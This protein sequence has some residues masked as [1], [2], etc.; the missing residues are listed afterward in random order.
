MKVLYILTFLFLLSFTVSGQILPPSPDAPEITVIGKKWR[1]EK[2]NNALDED[3]FRDLNN[4]KQAI[5]DR[6]ITDNNNKI[7][8]ASGEPPRATPVRMNSIE[9]PRVLSSDVKYIYEIKIK[10][11]GEKAI[12][13]ISCQYI[14]SEPDTQKQIS[15]VSFDKEININPGKTE[16]LTLISLSPPSG[17]VDATKAD[18]KLRDQYAELVIIQR[19][20][21]ADGSIWTAKNNLK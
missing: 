5:R 4:V 20:E 19:I 2:R 6:K 21:Y 15:Y 17:A 12:K 13:K 9:E 7:L 3:P 16:K 10:N 1:F 14:F 8:I 11:T 18:K